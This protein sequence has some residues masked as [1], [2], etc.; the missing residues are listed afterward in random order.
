MQILKYA[1]EVVM[2]NSTTHSFRLG[3]QTIV[4]Q[5]L[6]GTIVQALDLK[7]QSPMGVAK[8]FLFPLIQKCQV[9]NKITSRFFPFGEPFCSVDD[10]I[11]QCKN[12]ALGIN[13]IVSNNTLLRSCF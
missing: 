1:Q 12:S 8:K 2:E 10:P 5:G 7:S 3:K 9:T 4:L 11:I 13:Q 6:Q